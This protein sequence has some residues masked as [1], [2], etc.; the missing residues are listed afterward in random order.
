MGYHYFHYKLFEL[1]P[2]T[3]LLSVRLVRTVFLVGD[4]QQGSVGVRLTV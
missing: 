2:F 1:S 4:K 3:Y